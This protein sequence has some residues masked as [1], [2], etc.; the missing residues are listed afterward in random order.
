MVVGHTPQGDGKVNSRCDGAIILG[1]TVI[2]SAYEPAF[3]FSSP[4]AIELGNGQA[5]ARYF[6]KGNK[7]DTEA[8]V[9]PEGQ[10]FV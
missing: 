9:S 10:I 8:P 2:S 7:V 3:G 1:D 6:G 4:S 5:T